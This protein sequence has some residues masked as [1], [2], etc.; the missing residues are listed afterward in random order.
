MT[1]LVLQTTNRQ[2]KS[3]LLMGWV[4]GR[5]AGWGGGKGQGGEGGGKGVR[6][7]RGG[8]GRR[9]ERGGETTKNN[10]ACHLK[11][12]LARGF[13]NKFIFDAFSNFTSLTTMLDQRLKHRNSMA[14]QSIRHHFRL[15]IRACAVRV[16]VRACVC[17]CV[18]WLAPPP[19]PP[20]TPLTPSLKRQKKHTGIRIK[21]LTSSSSQ[22]PST[23]DSITNDCSLSSQ[24]RSMCIYI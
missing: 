20:P 2:G 11:L 21:N 4:G 5:A 3:N 18:L 10:D 17:V 12:T 15:R 6:G 24:S 1:N 16:C 22:T 14:K 23:T 8:R 9:R 19:P 7:G 13:Y